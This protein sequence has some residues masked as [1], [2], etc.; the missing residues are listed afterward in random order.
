MIALAVINL[1]GLYFYLR[2]PD[3]RLPRAIGSSER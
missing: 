3:Q 2:A 1:V